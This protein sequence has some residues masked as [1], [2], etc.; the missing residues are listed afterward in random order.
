M[1]AID[2]TTLLK[3]VGKLSHSDAPDSFSAADT[4]TV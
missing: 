1:S 2:L 4:T 3:L